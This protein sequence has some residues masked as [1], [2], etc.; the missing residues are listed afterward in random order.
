MKALSA[1][2]ISLTISFFSCSLMGQKNIKGISLA[3]G[4]PGSMSHIKRLE[5]KDVDV[6]LAGE[7][8]Q[9]ETYEYMRDAVDQ[10]RK[11]AIIFLGHIASEEAGMDYCAD[12]LKSFIKDIPVTFIESGP[13]YWAY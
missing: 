9:W 1:I 13:S 4:A 2:C 7:S 3:V 5:N 8:P 6:L 11:K 12:W 10:G